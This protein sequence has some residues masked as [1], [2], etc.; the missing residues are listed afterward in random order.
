AQYVYGQ[1]MVA[2]TG[3]GIDP[4]LHEKLQGIRLTMVDEVRSRWNHHRRAARHDGRVP[5]AILQLAPEYKHA[6]VADLDHNR[7]YLFANNDGLPRLIG[8]FYATI[9][10]QGADKRV[11][12]DNRTPI[13]IYR[14]TT[15][16]NGD[17]LPELYGTGAF[18]LNY[19]NPY[20]QLRGRTGYGIW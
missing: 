8:D 18:P 16:R 1:L 3:N 15:Y 14:I 4:S 11:A 7:L 12:G 2:R 6:I 13:G 17:Q 19:P 10:S 5:A 20:D 9:G